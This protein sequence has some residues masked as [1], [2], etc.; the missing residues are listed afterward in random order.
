MNTLDLN[1]D[2]GRTAFNP[3]ETVSV[4]LNW[5]LQEKV[6][7]IKLRLIYFTNDEGY[8]DFKMVQAESIESPELIDSETFKFQ[9]PTL[10]YSFKGNL[11]SLTWAF[12]A[13]LVP[14]KK[15]HQQKIV[16]G[17]NQTRV[18]LNHIDKI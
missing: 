18:C 16:I 3:G 14:L 1:I 17:P 13:E 10:P 12:E 11:F 8:T 6:D 4:Q 9:L 2:D 15:F 7:E 5:E